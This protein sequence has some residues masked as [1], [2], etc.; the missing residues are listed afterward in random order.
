VIFPFASNETP[1]LNK[2]SYVTIEMEEMQSREW[3]V[4]MGVTIGNSSQSASCSTA[5][6]FSAPKIC[7]TELT[8]SYFPNAANAGRIF[9]ASSK[10]IAP[11]CL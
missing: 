3:R 9:V 11:R 10:K 5:C 6:G 1:K 7:A 8:R 2:E 4:C